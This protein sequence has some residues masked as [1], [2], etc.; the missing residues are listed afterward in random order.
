MSL[1]EELLATGLM[2]VEQQLDDL[3]LQVKDCLHT[4]EERVTTTNQASVDAMNARLESFFTYQVV[5]N[6]QL[7]RQEK[8]DKP[9]LTF[10]LPPPSMNIIDGIENNAKFKFGESAHLDDCLQYIED[11]SSSSFLIA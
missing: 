2:R 10:P 11:D 1:D 9:L 7:A 8:V 5:V 4:I 6:Q 3:N